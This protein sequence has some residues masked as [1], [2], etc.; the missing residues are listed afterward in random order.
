MEPNTPVPQD[1]PRSDLIAQL[2]EAY[3]RAAYHHKTQQKAADLTKANLER[4]QGAQIALS[5]I[6]TSGIIFVFFDNESLIAKGLAGIASALLT[7]LT[8]YMKSSKHGDV[9]AAHQKAA[10]ELWLVRERYLCLLTDLNARLVDVDAA[11]LRRD[12]LV[13]DLGQLHARAPRTSDKAY[14]R[15]QFA[16]KREQEMFFTE[17]ELDRMLPAHLR[18]SKKIASQS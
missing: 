7:A 3:G 14:K 13:C 11:M 18:S 9:A 6:T 12:E 15:A 17:V 4:F 1:S 5:A 10:S 8:V 2:K 16:L